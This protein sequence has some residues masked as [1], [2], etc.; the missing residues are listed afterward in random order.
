MRPTL[1]WLLGQDISQRARRSQGLPPG[2]LQSSPCWG[3]FTCLS[4]KS[5]AVEKKRDEIP[6]EKA[7]RGREGDEERA[8]GRLSGSRTWWDAASRSQT[9]FVLQLLPG[10]PKEPDAGLG[11]PALCLTGS[12]RPQWADALVSLSR[13]GSEHLHVLM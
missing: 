4:L 1:G 11:A 2:R 5:Q 8:R 6:L 7:P 12:P 13:L 10:I 3:N 9:P